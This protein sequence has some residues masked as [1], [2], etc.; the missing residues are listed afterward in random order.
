MEHDSDSD[1]DVVVVGAGLAGLAAADA[2]STATSSLAMRVVVLEAR[3]RV[4]GRV[5]SVD[6]A[7]HLAREDQGAAVSVDVGAQWIGPRHVEMLE[8]VRRFGLE[9]ELVEQEYPSASATHPTMM[10]TTTTHPRRLT[11]CVGYV[12]DPLS[13]AA[14]AELDAF[15]ARVDA[16]GA[17]LD[18]DC[19]GN[20]ARAKEWDHESVEQFVRRELHTPEAQQEA[21]VF[22]QTVLACAP[23]AIS[24][25]FFLFYVRSGGGMDALGDGEFGAQRWRVRG[26]MQ[27]IPDLL[28]DDVRKRGVRIVLGEPV[29]SISRVA[30]TASATTTATAT[31]GFKFEVKSRSGK[32]WRARSVVVAVAPQIV[33]HGIHFFPPRLVSESKE[34]MCQAL[35]PGHVVKM[36]AVFEDAFWLRASSPASGHVSE[37]GLVHNLFHSAVDVGGGRMMPALVG[38]ATGDAA[39]ALQHMAPPA[40][41]DAFLAQLARMYSLPAP[42]REAAF[43]D[44]VWP[45]EEFSRG[46]FAGVAPPTGAFSAH[47]ASL[48]SGDTDGVVLCST[49]TSTEAFGYME[50]AVLAGKRAAAAIIAGFS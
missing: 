17:E 31:K 8:L 4:G 45:A 32:T 50:G 2:L 34:K 46:C 36:V 5:E 10:K 14:A 3:T 38:L 23:R 13:P 28:A 11:E 33:A 9:S 26:G 29:A 20:H 19:P 16:W 18:L 27:R 47:A 25:L 49:E 39:T 7:V 1:A 30:E 6:V 37:L 15:I 22:A 48:R 21:L 35:V 24:F 42:P 41:R 40:R 44:R 43:I 12:D